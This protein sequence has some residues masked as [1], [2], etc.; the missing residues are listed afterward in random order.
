M[1][2]IRVEGRWPGSV[3]RAL[4]RDG[5]VAGDEQVAFVALQADHRRPGNVPGREEGGR[6]P[7]AQRQARL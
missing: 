2:H 1:Q 7:L 3:H 4:R 5:D 6:Q